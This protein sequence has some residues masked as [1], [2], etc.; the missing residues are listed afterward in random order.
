MTQITIA[1]DG[2]GG[3]VGPDVV[4][5]A[6]LQAL[7]ATD[8]AVRLILVGQ[9]DVLSAQLAKLKAKGHPG[10][11]I[12]HASQLVSMDEPPA[13]ALRVKKDSSMR[14]A[15]DLVKDGRGYLPNGTMTK[16][17]RHSGAKLA[18]GA[19]VARQL[20]RALTKIGRPARSTARSWTSR[21]PVVWATRGT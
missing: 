9:E 15:M 18:R 1:L 12:R 2:M 21:S 4:V 6:A 3:D 10:I 20:N 7:K 16:G 17:G 5:P 11:V 19:R 8:G 13:Q 14:V